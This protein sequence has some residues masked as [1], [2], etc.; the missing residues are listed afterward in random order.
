MS[1]PKLKAADSAPTLE[2]LMEKQSDNAS[3]PGCEGNITV[4]GD[5]EEPTVIDPFEPFPEANDNPL[6]ASRIVTVRSILVGCILGSLVN[7]SNLYLGKS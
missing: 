6:E 4:K 5:G 3:G 1:S 7:A 2:F